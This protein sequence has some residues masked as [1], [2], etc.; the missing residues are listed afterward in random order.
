VIR[1][2]ARWVLPVSSAPVRDATV[3]VEGT[4]IAWVG[5]RTDAP[6]GVDVEL[7]DAVLLPGLV[8]AHVH[9]DLTAFSGILPRSSFF[10]W[11][12]TLVRALSEASDEDALRDVSRWTLA[13]QLSRGV[14][15][16]AHTGQGTAA[17]DAMLELGARGIAFL[18]VF[19]PDPAQCASSMDAL[20]KSVHGARSRESDRVRIGVSPHA[21]YSVSDD[22]YAAVA[23][24]ALEEQLPVAAHIAESASETMLVRDGAGEF[25][26][27]LRGRAIQVAPRASSPVQLLA[28]TG[29]LRTRPLCIH[30]IAIHDADIRSMSEAGATVAHCPRANSW[31]RHDSARVDALLSAGIAVGLGTDSA[32]SNDDLDVLAEA[33]S[34]AG[35]LSPAMRLE[36][37]TLGGARALGMDQM[38]GALRPGLQAD[39][40]AFG[41]ADAVACDADPALYLLGRP[42]GASALLTVV[43]GNIVSRGG[44]VAG[45]GPEIDERMRGHR[46][47]ALAW[48]DGVANANRTILDS[49]S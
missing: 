21:P 8:N 13:A 31:L 5:P 12:R 33:K 2:N 14:T 30:A 47:R 43:A 49:V 18:E 42:A 20:R 36:L 32:A 10:T 4:S 22:L 19:G 6:P 37:A 29:L 1:Y 26:D 16:M 38:V 24:F 15:T 11:V 39:L 25:A 23:A 17:L 41:I 35:S 28:K 45:V 27:L 9:L 48:R 44:S 40:A 34:A 3:V 46:A 7:G